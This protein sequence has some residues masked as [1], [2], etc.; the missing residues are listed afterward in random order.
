MSRLFFVL[1]S[2]GS[3]FLEI[4]VFTTAIKRFVLGKG[5]SAESNL[6]FLPNDS[7]VAECKG[8]AYL[9]GSIISEKILFQELHDISLEVG[10]PLGTVLVSNM[11]LYMMHFQKIKT[12]FKHEKTEK[13]NP[14]TDLI[15]GYKQASPIM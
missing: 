4:P 5:N 1:Q 14:K 8:L 9:K 12:T 13:S 15:I 10:Q 3:I 6:Q 11:E 7:F 2:I